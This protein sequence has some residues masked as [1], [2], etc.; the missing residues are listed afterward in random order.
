[1]NIDKYCYKCSVPLHF[2]HRKLHCY[3]CKKI[4][5]YNCLE[6]KKHLTDHHKHTI[7]HTCYIYINEYK[8]L[9]DIISIF[10]IL[11]I[12]LKEY[13]ILGQVC[14]TWNKVYRYFIYK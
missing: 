14:V 3:N 2:I 10:N 4:F 11:P 13:Y 12:S 1:M 5:C 7:C 9:K 8:E 6:Y